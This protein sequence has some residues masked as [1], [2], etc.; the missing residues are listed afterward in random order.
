VTIAEAASFIAVILAALATYASSTRKAE[1]DRLSARVV[2]LEKRLSD[3][4]QRANDNER[5][6]R[7]RQDVIKRQQLEKVY[8]SIRRLN[9][10]SDGNNKIRMVVLALE[11]LFDDF[12]TATGTKPDLDLEALKRL[13]VI[14][15]VTDRLGTID[16]HAARKFEDG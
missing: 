3:A 1:I 2:D 12:E 8:E 5:S 7:Y 13:S 15:H 4:E 9:L 6:D 16:V 10:V 14:D 11:K